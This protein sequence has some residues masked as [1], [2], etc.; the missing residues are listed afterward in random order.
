M[1]R[2]LSVLL[3]GMLAIGSPV[4]PGTAQPRDSAAQVV[5][6]LREQNPLINDVARYDPDGLWNLLSK[7]ESL[8]SNRGAPARS[9]I[10]ATPDEQAQIAANPVIHQAYG[11]DPGGT[12]QLLRDTNEALRKARQGSELGLPQRLAL[13]V[14]DGGSDAWGRLGNADNDAR[15]IAQTLK[16]LGFALVSGAALINPD[17]AHLQ[18]AIKDFGHSIGPQTVSLF[19]FAGHGIQY[20]GHN[21]LV[22]AGAIIPQQEDDYDRSLVEVDGTVLRRMQ[23]AGGRLNIIVLDA[24]RDHPPPPRTLIVASRGGPVHGLAATN[25]P[26]GMNGTVFIYSTAPNDIARDRVNDDDTDSPF[27]KAFAEAVVRPGIEMRD[28]FDEI[29]EGVKQA[30]HGAQQ[31]WISYAA[32]GKFSF[33]DRP[34]IQNASSR[35]LVPPASQPATPE[36]T[37]PQASQASSRPAISPSTIQPTPLEPSKSNPSTEQASFRPLAPAITP[38]SMVPAPGGSV[39]S[40]NEASQTPTHPH[41]TQSTVTKPPAPIRKSATL[42][43]SPPVIA[44]PLVGSVGNVPASVSGHGDPPPS[45]AP[46]KVY[47]ATKFCE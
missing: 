37:V 40:G 25:A 28:T 23:E 8:I 42:K 21:Y 34:P 27:A 7:L 22:P 41:N 9:G 45:Q 29:Q 44:S 18:Q 31:P 10:P 47:G 39:P 1:R 14:G 36:A 33:S 13:V 43:S 12:L 4:T 2:L 20:G 38:P 5:V 19:Y 35:I 16:D 26:P 46:C 30:T 6:P 32:I 3:T 11:S 15:L 24:C 17:K